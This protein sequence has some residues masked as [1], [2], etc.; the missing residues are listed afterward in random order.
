MGNTA[1]DGVVSVCHDKCGLSGA[2]ETMYWMGATTGRG[3]FKEDI[4]GHGRHA[5]WV[6]I[7]KV[8]HKGAAL[9]DA[10]CSPPLPRQLLQTSCTKQ[11]NAAK[12]PYIPHRRGKFMQLIRT[13]C[14]AYNYKAITAV[15]V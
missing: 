13:L 6:D 9:G 12:I 2:Q 8:A 4:L 14:C 15:T 11:T 5:Q 1:T 7:L 10:A 3:T